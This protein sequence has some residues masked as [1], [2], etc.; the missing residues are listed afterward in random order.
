MIRNWWFGSAVVA[1]GISSV[2]WLNLVS[3][4]KYNAPLVYNSLCV[5][6]HISGDTN[7][8]E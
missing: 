5:G 8:G 1:F 6:K 4:K 3:S 2:C 7:E